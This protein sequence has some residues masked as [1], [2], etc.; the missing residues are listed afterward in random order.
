MNMVLVLVIVVI[1]ILIVLLL[2]SYPIL[3]QRLLPL[4]L[5]VF[6]RLRPLLLLFLLR[7]SQVSRSRFT[8]HNEQVLATVFGTTW[9]PRTVVRVENLPMVFEDSI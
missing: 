7:R 8:F 9:D 6:L 2:H 4:L 1:V 5:L 3:L